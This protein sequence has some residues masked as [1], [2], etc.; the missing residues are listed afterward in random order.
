LFVENNTDGSKKREAKTVDKED[1]MSMVSDN[2]TKVN[3]RMDVQL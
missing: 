2:T 3:T 1:A